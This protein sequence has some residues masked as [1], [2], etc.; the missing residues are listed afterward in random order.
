DGSS[1]GA[2]DPLVERGRRGALAAAFRLAD[3]SGAAGV[4][5]LE[6]P[7]DDNPAKLIVATEGGGP[8]RTLLSAGSDLGDA[9]VAF[10]QGEESG[11]T[12]AATAIDA[13]PA[14][15]SAATPPDYVNDAT[16]ELA[17]D[18]A[19]SAIGSVTYEV[20]IDG[21]AVASKLKGLKSR[22]KASAIGDGDH[23]VTVTATDSGDQSTS[24]PVASL[25]LDRTPPKVR[26]SLNRRARRATVVLSDGAKDDTSG[27]AVGSST[28]S[29]GDGRR[30][31]GRRTLKHRYARAGTFRITVT[32]RDKV[33]NRRVV[34]KV[35]RVG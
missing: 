8:V 33:G 31:S 28:V 27:V 3:A 20:L 14:A 10:L 2:P 15:F 13:P 1:T 34:R 12:I 22:V 26:T 21:E 32:A 19:P 18:A 7:S 9:A 11:A 6:R 4:G 17:W 35:V 25:K 5:L 16:V 24:T 30:A 23:Q 29:W